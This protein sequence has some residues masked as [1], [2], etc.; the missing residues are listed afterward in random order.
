[1]FLTVAGTAPDGRPRVLLGDPEWGSELSGIALPEG[2][3]LEGFA[4]IDRSLRERGFNVLRNPLPFVY[5]DNPDAKLRE[6][7]YASANNCWVECEGEAGRVFLPEYGFGAWERLK[8]SDEVNATIWEGLGFNVIR[9]GDF[10][11]L[12]DQLGSLNCVTRILE[13]A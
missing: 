13:R 5:Y 1:M 4:A 10:L 6:W 2:F 9:G 12:A 3:P 7:F 11:P 8:A